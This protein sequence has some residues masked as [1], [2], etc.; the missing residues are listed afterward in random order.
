MLQVKK[1][2]KVGTDGVLL[3]KAEYKQYKKLLKT[4]TVF[5][6]YKKDYDVTYKSGYM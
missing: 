4:I 2:Q 6:S 5:K 3:T 1:G